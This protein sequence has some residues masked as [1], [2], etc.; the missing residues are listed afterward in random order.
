MSLE[1]TVRK[2]LMFLSF[3]IL[4]LSL[5]AQK[6]PMKYGKVDKADLEMTAYPLD[7]TASA[8]ILC[9]YGYFDAL[10]A[11]FVHLIRIKVLKEE[12][13]SWGSY[14]AP[15]AKDASV[16]GQTVTLEN[17]VAVVSKLKKESTFV[18][19]ITKGAY[20]VRV[21]MPNVK[22]GSVI[23]LEIYY[24]GLPRYWR[25]QE[26]IPVRWSELIIE[27][28]QYYSF[29]KNYKGYIPLSESDDMRWVTKDVPAFKSEPYIDNADNYIT[30]FDIEISML[31]IP[32]ISLYEE[33]ATTWDAVI[34]TL[35]KDN[36]FGG[37]LQSINFFLGDLV[38][39]IKSTKSTPEERMEM[40][41]NELKMIKWDKGES[42]WP[43]NSMLSTAFNKKTGNVADINLIL[44]L[45]LRK[46]DIDADPVVLSTRDNGRLP[47]FS[48]SMRKLNY[49]IARAKIGDNS[50]VMDATDENLP[51]GML[52][53]RT[54]N[55]RGLV[56][57]RDLL[58]WVDLTPT[59]KDKIVSVFSG[60]L[61]TDGTIK[62]EWSKSYFAYGALDKRNEYK[63]FNSQDE[64]LKSVESANVGSSIDSYTNENLD[65][66]SKPFTE[67][68]TVTLKNRVTKANNQL[69][70][71]PL[72]FGK[73][74]ENPFKLEER[75]YPVDFT[76]PL[77]RIQILHLN[78]PE[79]YAI[80]K[81]PES[82]KMV[83]PE[84][85]ASFL[86]Q[87][88][89]EERTIHLLYKLNINKPIFLQQ[90][91]NDLK[92]FIDQLIKKHAEM[93]VIKKV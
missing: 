41:Y 15:A 79:G 51:F 65:S 43:S 19:K 30:Q 7:S 8:V 50:Y 12:G 39:K 87:L 55:G 37:H 78:I 29:K 93:L 18:E 45:L 17:G 60:N 75:L 35:D 47:A 32:S 56:V 25:F 40:A 62:G 54:F 85:S 46:L 22:V 48:V 42:I 69:Y 70:V 2:A 59:S 13:K 5:E 20:R 64:Y 36:D 3:F 53:K 82:V 49:V 52:S 80:E 77:E 88:T 26:S 73:W 27:P 66:L 74:T 81:L 61:K 58:D 84:G 57:K 28:N 90:E 14:I 72:L 86:M 1:L 89:S 71:E 16:K 24:R 31:H 23:D 76:T 68:F 4:V 91:Y 83:M 11:Q 33:Y 38:K 44:V 63:T 10:N 9:N 6:A 92:M 67:N 21:A 34:S